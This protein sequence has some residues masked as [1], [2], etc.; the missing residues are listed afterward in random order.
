[1]ENPFL[2]PIVLFVYNR[3]WHTRQTVEA[4][5]KNELVADSELFIFSDAP[6]N[7][8]A[9]DNVTDVREYCNTITGFK[10]ITIIER[11]NNWGLANSIIDGVTK[12]V[13]EDGRVIVLEDD[14]VTSPFFLMYMN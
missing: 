7:E 12:I 10:K 9:I 5:Q 11:D 3:L 6:K 13:N 14:L 8:S 2:A 4:L 1:M